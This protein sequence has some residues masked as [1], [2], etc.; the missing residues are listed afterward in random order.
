MAMTSGVRA[1]RPPRRPRRIA[2]LSIHTSPVDVPGTGDAG[3]MNVYV[4]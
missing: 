4:V 2:V 1:L 3:G